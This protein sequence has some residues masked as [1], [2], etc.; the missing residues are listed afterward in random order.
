LNE[1]IVRID[2]E[3]DREH[4][5]ELELPVTE[6]KNSE[7]LEISTPPEQ[8]Y[9]DKLQEVRRQLDSGL[10]PSITVRQFLSWFGYARRGHVVVRQIRDALNDAELHTDPDFEYPFIDSP[11]AFL[12][13]GVSPAP[14][15]QIVSDKSEPLSPLNGPPTGPGP[16]PGSAYSDPTYRIGKLTFANRPPVWIHP[17]RELR[18]AL[19]L[20]LRHDYSQ[21]P[22]MTSE[23]DVRGMISWKTIALRTNLGTQS[24]LVKECMD[25]PPEMVN[26][27]MSL[28]RVIKTVVE[29]ECVL[30]RD[31][32]RKI[33]GIVTAAD[34]SETLDQLGRP[35][36]L[37]GEIENHIR[38]LLD[39]KFTRDELQKIRISDDPGREVKDVSD[40]TFGEY[41]RLI[42]DPDRWS[43]INLRLDRVPFVKDLEAVNRIRNDVMHFDPEG[44]TPEEL[45]QL[46]ETAKFLQEVRVFC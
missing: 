19:H 36:L 15:Q 29:H 33:T 27:D 5:S 35:F 6:T 39:G 3:I 23:R 13:A 9:V 31:K 4:E 12:K 38:G 8:E 2:N 44:I 26:E 7:V 16:T 34:L 21:L 18:A 24:R 28:F 22:V 45:E 42:Q 30:V 32:T 40:L 10:S 14:T 1:E 11:I 17:D 46:V 37:L 43:R 20:M 25:G 41:V